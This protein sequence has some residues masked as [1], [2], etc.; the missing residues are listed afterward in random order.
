[1]EHGQIAVF[2]IF[3]DKEQAKRSVERLTDSEF[4]QEEV[5]LLDPS[6]LGTKDLAHNSDVRAG[7]ST[8][9]VTT[10]VAAGGAVGLVAGVGA[11]AIPGV[12]P[13]LAAAPFLAALAGMG[14]GGLIG[15][16]IDAADM[17]GPP[18]KHAKR[19]EGHIREGGILVTVHCLHG[20]VDRAKELLSETGAQ[21]ISSSDQSNAD[22]QANT[23]RQINS[24]ES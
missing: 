2:G 16:A 15:G 4:A 20:K 1:M 18:D 17:A 10:S 6:E 7:S 8:A 19:Y 24:N 22:F 9:V 21:A 11:L 23:D 13:A 3:Y 14:A 12:G 5:S